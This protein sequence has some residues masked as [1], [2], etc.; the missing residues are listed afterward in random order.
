MDDTD[1]A[2]KLLQSLNEMASDG[3]IDI[4]KFFY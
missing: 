2:Q 4:E 3:T 1:E